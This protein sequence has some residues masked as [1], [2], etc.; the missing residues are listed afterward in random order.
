[1]RIKADKDNILNNSE[2]ILRL[3]SN[4]SL[5][6]IV[7]NGNLYEE[8]IQGLNNI[9]KYK[10]LLT[11]P[12]FI[13]SD[14]HP[15]TLIPQWRDFIHSFDGKTE[16]EK[17]ADFHNLLE[18][19]RLFVLSVMQHVKF[20]VDGCDNEK[21]VKKESADN[22][23]CFDS[24]TNEYFASVAFFNDKGVQ[25]DNEMLYQTSDEDIY[26]EVMK[27]YNL[28]SDKYYK[29]TESENKIIDGLKGLLGQ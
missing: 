4:E 2:L 27:L 16:K 10:D 5:K 11:Y 15:R 20:C 19:T 29:K 12:I 21:T 1:M 3:I 22:I 6:E 14:A 28:I 23:P 18:Q 24:F 13:S 17:L 9:L 7:H 26:N 25:F 8:V